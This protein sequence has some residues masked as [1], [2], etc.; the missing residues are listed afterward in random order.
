M[1][2]IVFGKAGGCKTV[3]VL[4]VTFI[5]FTPLKLSKPYNSS[6]LNKHWLKYSRQPVLFHSDLGLN[7]ESMAI[8]E[9]LKAD[10]ITKQSP[11]RQGKL[12]LPVLI[13]LRW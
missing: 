12:A 9:L 8:A 6:G 10:N 11:T 4:T 7:F 5:Q 3:L 13:A 2:D 1:F